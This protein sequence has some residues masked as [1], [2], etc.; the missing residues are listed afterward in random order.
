M[1]K[2][3]DIHGLAEQEAII[4]IEKFIASCDKDIKEIV[5]IHGFH[6]GDVLKEMVRSPRKIRSK[7][8]KRISK[9]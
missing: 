4:V 6:S 9:G 7:R 5:V 3:L 8:I 2:E 1:T